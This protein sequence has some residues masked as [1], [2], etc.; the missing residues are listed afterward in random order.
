MRAKASALAL[1]LGLIV[2]LASC[3][4]TDGSVTAVPAETSGKAIPA[5]GAIAPEGFRAVTLIV[6]RPDGTVTY[7]CVWLADSRELR[8]KGLTGIT[9]PDLGGKEGMVFRFEEDTSATFWMKD[10]M[11]PL[12]VAWFDSDGVFISSTSMEPCP[13]D[14]ES[15]PSHAPAGPYRLALETTKGR[16]AESGLEPGSRVELGDSC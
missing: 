1:V 4:S 5:S 2:G 15:C 6:T 7:L 11:L 3:G 10:T 8:I 9:D 12:S 16:L 13:A 14:S